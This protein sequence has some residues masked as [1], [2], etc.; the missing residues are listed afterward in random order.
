MPTA[1]TLNTLMMGTVDGAVA[2]MEPNR[3][4]CVAP[5]VAE[6]LVVRYKNNEARPIEVPRTMPVARSLPRTWRTPMASMAPAPATAPKTKPRRGL[7]PMRK[8]PDPPVADASV[9]AWP[10]ND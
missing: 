7:I 8:V 1:T 4:C 10:A 6:V 2:K 5:V 9:S 3:I